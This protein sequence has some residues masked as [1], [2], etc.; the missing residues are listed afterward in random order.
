MLSTIIIFVIILSLLVFVH[1]FGHFISAKKLGVKV[2]EFGIGFPPRIWKIEK[3]ETTYSLN[4]IPIGGF[5][6]LKGEDGANKADEDS[7][8]HKAIWKR[9]IILASGVVMNFILAIIVLSIGFRIG[10]PQDLDSIE[11]EKFAKV[12]DVKI[13]VLGTL[14]NFPA[15][16]AG[17]QAGDTILDIDGNKFSD[18]EDVQNY[19]SSKGQDRI[20]ITLFRNDE[21]LQKELV[22]IPIDANSDN[23]FKENQGYAVGISLAKTGTV[24]YP[25]YIAIWKGTQTTGFLMKEIYKAFY[26][27]ITH[28]GGAVELGGPVEIASM[29][30]KVAS[31]GFIYILQFIALLSIN[32]GIIN[33][34]P[35][36]ALDGGRIFFL[37]I[38]KIR[39][40]VTNQ[41][42]ENFIH[43]VGFAILML[44]IIFITY[45]D[46][47]NHKT[48]FIDFFNKIFR[49]F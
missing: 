37:I 42:V 24:S 36:P 7:F 5:V 34:I 47:M 8:A 21:T 13:Q 35:F 32:L 48:A 16:E 39:G 31:L 3:G 17:I 11:N 30:G 29:T 43:T 44:L 18:V 41:N 20:L 14:E 46:I 12:R 26:M 40:K 27:L 9:L 19:I 4:W 49:V 1:E 15:K 22:A 25:F 38:E 45:K 23:S 28:K 33:L 6:K 2:E 10:F